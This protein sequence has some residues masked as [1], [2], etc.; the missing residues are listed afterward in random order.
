MIHL[1]P[2]HT[3]ETK[4]FEDIPVRWLIFLLK[5]LGICGLFEKYVQDGRQR[6][7]T[8]S[9]TSLLMVALEILL[10][11]S[12]SKNEFY[13]NKKFER[14]ACYRNL[15]KI[16][17]IEEDTFPHSKTIDDAFLS[18]DPSDL[19]PILFDVFKALHSAKLFSNH[20]SLKKHQTYRLGIDA[21]WSHHY[22]ALS[23]HP[24]E[25]CPFCLKRERKMKEGETKVWYVHIEVV[26]SL[27]FENGF[28]MPL[29]VHRI[30]KKRGWEELSEESLKQ[31]CELTAFP[32]VLA[33]IRAYLPKL[34]ITAVLDGLYANQTS[35]DALKR[36]CFDWDIVLKRLKSVQEEID[37]IDLNVRSIASKRFNLTQTA[38]FTNGIPYGSHLLNAVDF[39]EHAQ[40]KSSKRF[41]K[42][43]SKNVHYQW[44]V[45]KTVDKTSLFGLIEEARSRWQ[46]EDLIN[47]IK[48]RGFHIKHD[49]NRHP[50]CQTIWK[51]L[52]FLAFCITAIFLLSD[53]GIKARKG[54]TIIF[55]MKQMLQDLFYLPYEEIFLCTYP[56]QLRFSLCA[57]AS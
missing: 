23:Q 26:A 14:E 22:T 49:Y 17:Q 34:K 57:C 25:A 8:Y 38:C 50:S 19:E 48:N 6:Q 53:L 27:I 43:N 15:G 13:Q 3:K 35:I 36:F 52:T 37:P 41:A 20:P 24:C 55:L 29:C 46:E 42:I 5:R 11:R 39:Y 40:K 4:K 9:I 18:L 7:G 2:N 45:H 33:K 10:F 12:P 32:L 31:E 51:I 1:Y 56:K 44:I 30:R 28:Q 54:V 47:T 21:F 16:A